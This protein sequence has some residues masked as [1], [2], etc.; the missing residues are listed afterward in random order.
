MW[1]TIH[2]LQT[3]CGSY[4]FLF[5]DTAVGLKAADMHGLP[6][7]RKILVNG[8]SEHSALQIARL[9]HTAQH[10]KISNLKL[11]HVVTRKLSVLAI[12]E[13]FQFQKNAVTI[14]DDAGARTESHDIEFARLEQYRLL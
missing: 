8:H 4:Y 2:H 9:S 6:K 7:C 11:I 5:C 3:L 1:K 10:L 12:V 13:H 14:L